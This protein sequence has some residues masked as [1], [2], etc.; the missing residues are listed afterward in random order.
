MTNSP[1]AAATSTAS[2]LYGGWLRGRGSLA[3]GPPRAHFRIEAR[4]RARNAKRPHL[5]A[6]LYMSEKIIRAISVD[7]VPGSAVF[8]QLVAQ[9]AH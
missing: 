3:K 8:V 2:T 9:R 4:T 6:F 1:K 7:G 5:R